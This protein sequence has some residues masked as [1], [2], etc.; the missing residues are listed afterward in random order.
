MR[1]PMNERSFGQKQGTALFGA[2]TSQM[3]DFL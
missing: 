3:H 2:L 1:W